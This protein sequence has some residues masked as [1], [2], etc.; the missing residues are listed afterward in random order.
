MH[1]L[2]SNMMP[3]SKF[4]VMKGNLCDFLRH[5]G[6]CFAV[7]SLDLAAA[8]T[9]PCGVR[10]DEEQQDGIDTSWLKLF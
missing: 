10:Q 6:T 8:V 1:T 4:K 9:R 5:S 7:W 3:Y 2:T